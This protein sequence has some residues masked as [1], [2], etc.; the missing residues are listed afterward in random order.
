MARVWNALKGKA[1]EM[2]TQNKYSRL[3]SIFVAWKFHIKEKIILKKYLN[4]CN[5]Q[6]APANKGK[7][8]SIDIDI[9]FKENVDLNSY[10]GVSK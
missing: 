4:E 5:Y 7:D 6:A 9:D 8:N 1:L 10:R 2:K 3:Y